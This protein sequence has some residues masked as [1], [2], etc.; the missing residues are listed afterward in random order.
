MEDEK[1]FPVFFLVLFFLSSIIPAA[2][3]VVVVSFLPTVF[4]CASKRMGVDFRT[5]T[6]ENHDFAR[7]EGTKSSSFSF[8]VENGVLI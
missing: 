7:R 6:L 4:K 5:A 2:L 1:D 8:A 3:S